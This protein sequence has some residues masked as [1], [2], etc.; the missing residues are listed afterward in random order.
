MVE[1]ATESVALQERSSNL[2]PETTQVLV[3]QLSAYY[4]IILESTSEIEKG[5]LGDKSRQEA[6]RHLLELGDLQGM[7]EDFTDNPNDFDVRYQ[8]VDHDSGVH[9]AKLSRRSDAPFGEGEENAQ[10]QLNFFMQTAQRGESVEDSTYAESMG[11]DPH[12]AML[13]RDA[14]HSGKVMMNTNLIYRDSVTGRTKVIPQAGIQ[15]KVGRDG[16]TQEGIKYVGTQPHVV[17]IPMKN[18]ISNL[19]VKSLQG[20]TRSLATERRQFSR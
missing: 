10:M 9:N 19:Q 12:N 20:L 14:L 15:V 2:A 18:G 4:G 8:K 5:D 17:E 1:T 6:E 3:D 16:I 7:L 11:N 13:R